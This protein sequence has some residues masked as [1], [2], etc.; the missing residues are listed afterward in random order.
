M[1]RRQP[2]SGRAAADGLARGPASRLAEDPERTVRRETFATPGA[3]DLELKVPAGRID[4]ETTDGAETTI[5]LEPIRDDEGTLAA[6]ESARVELRERAAGGQQVSVVIDDVGAGIGINLPFSRGSEESGRRV[7]FGF[8]RTPEVYVRV[9]CPH[10]AGLTADCSSADVLGRGRFG[11]TKLSTGSGDVELADTDDLSLNTASGDIQVAHV[12]GRAQINTASG[13]V[14]LKRLEGDAL[15]NTA[16]GDTL[17]DRVDA[18]LQVNSASGDVVVR[19]AAASVAVRTASGDH[20]LDSVGEGEVN[21]KSASGDIY[22][23]VRRGTKVWL[24]VRSRSGDTSSELDVS[25]DP[26]AEGAPMLELRAN[27]MSGDVR[28]ARASA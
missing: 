12:A 14:A 15:I 10:G 23:G 6:V 26:P 17:I 5:E 16:S 18:P 8:W 3:L 24:D 11:A 21:L 1:A 22:V 28:I 27:T 20:R 4:I 7:R 25:D 13:D 9:R 19:S 2:Q